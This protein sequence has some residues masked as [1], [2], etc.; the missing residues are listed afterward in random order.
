MREKQA[1]DYAHDREDLADKVKLQYCLYKLLMLISFGIAE[2]DAQFA[3]LQVRERDWPT[4]LP[5]VK[6]MYKKFVTHTYDLACNVIRHSTLF[7]CFL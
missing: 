3:N 4:P 7:I 6:P 2:L 5:G 1:K